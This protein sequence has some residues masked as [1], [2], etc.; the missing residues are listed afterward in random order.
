ACSAIEGLTR[1]LAAELGPSGIRVNCVRAAGMPETRTLQETLANMGKTT[2]AQGVASQTARPT[3]D[4][5]L[6]RPITVAETAQTVAFLA[7]DRASG[8][9]GQ[10]VN[11][12]G[13]VLIS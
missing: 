11:V 9:A 2:A 13:G 8:I 3:S 12:C 10:V 4:S 6:R 5:V 1:T 7:S